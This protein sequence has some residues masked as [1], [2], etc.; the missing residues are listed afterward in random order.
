MMDRNDLDGSRAQPVDDSIVALDHFAQRGVPNLRDHSARLGELANPFNCRH[1]TFTKQD[2][3]SGR[4]ASDVRSDGLDI[5]DGLAGPDDPHHFKIRFLASW[6]D[7]VSPASA[8][9]SPC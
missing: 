7:I 9:S 1:E 2:S 3:V 8:S 5:L 4:V 6:C